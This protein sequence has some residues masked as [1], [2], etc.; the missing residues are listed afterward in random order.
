[1]P[2][3]VVTVA[4]SMSSIVVSRLPAKHAIKNLL[5]LAAAFKRL[6]CIN[7][8]RKHCRRRQSSQTVFS[9]T[10]GERMAM[11]R[12]SN[13]PMEI[14]KRAILMRTERG[15]LKVRRELVSSR[16][17]DAFLP[18]NVNMVQR[19]TGLLEASF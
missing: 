2:Y 13:G 16:D 6:I 15:S 17:D 7:L 3:L 4:H 11:S 18:V 12:L 8:K 19:G 5:K 10:K 14:E 9:L 1:M